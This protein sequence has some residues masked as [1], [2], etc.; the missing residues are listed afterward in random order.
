[1]QTIAHNT[2]V[3]DQKT[4]NDGRE[5][6]SEAVW[7]DR[8]FF[9]ASNPNVQVM[10]AKT[11]KHYAG[12][13]MQRTMF[14]IRDARL[15]HPVVVDLFRLASGATHTYD[16]PIHFRG[17]L[18]TTTASYQANATRQEPMGTGHGYQHLWKEASG[19][20]DRPVS[21][22]WLDGSRYYTVLTA[23]SPN[24]EVLFGRTGANDPQFNLIS[25]PLMIVRRRANDH[26]FA[27]VIEPHGFFSEAMERSEEA[28][29]R[30]QAV[31]VVASDSVGS[32][33][34]VT[35]QGGLQWTI[36]VANGDASP[37]ATRRVGTYTWTGNWSVRGV[38]PPPR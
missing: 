18:I 2:V 17:Q 27:S 8:H 13:A 31:R 26:L 20:T 34:E 7:A 23:A 28:R 6:A 38:Q 35:A 3:V 29:P 15:R 1:M 12:V 37:T 24:T 33:I 4:Q 30:T 22:T 11:S 25:E 10:S 19:Y 32:V 21:L 14:L 16:Y 5:A 9:D 36:M